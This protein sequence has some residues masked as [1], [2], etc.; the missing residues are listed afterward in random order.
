MV[1][2]TRFANRS[3]ALDICVRLLSALLCQSLRQTRAG[4][5]LLH[6]RWLE[7]DWSCGAGGR[8][9]KFH[10]LDMGPAIVR[11]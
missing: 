3:E 6:A 4:C 10:W 1:V 8:G 5:T 11:C 7:M 2:H 9:R